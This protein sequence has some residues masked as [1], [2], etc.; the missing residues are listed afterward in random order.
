M[1]THLRVFVAG[2]LPLLA[3]RAGMALGEHVDDAKDHDGRNEQL[4]NLKEDFPSLTLGGLCTGAVR[5]ECDPVGY[6]FVSNRSVFIA[7]R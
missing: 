6:R 5:S 1:L 7:L 4:R 3:H 2:L